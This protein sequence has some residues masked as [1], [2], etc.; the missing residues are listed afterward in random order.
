MAKT[1]I[2]NKKMDRQATL[3][4]IVNFCATFMLVFTLGMLMLANMVG[5]SALATV[6]EPLTDNKCACRDKISNKPA[7]L[8]PVSAGEPSE[9]N[10]KLVVDDSG[11]LDKELILSAV[12]TKMLEVINKGVNPH[13]FVIDGMMIDSGVIKPGESK[14][15]ALESLSGDSQS[16]SFYSNLPGDNKEKFSGVFVVE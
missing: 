3:S 9:G 2:V 16:Y 12:G 10:I 11:Y 14:T 5:E 4:F 6:S 7:V 1:K 15:I 13:S 8:F